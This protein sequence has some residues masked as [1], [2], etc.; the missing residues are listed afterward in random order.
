MQDSFH[1]AKVAE[2]YKSHRGQKTEEKKKIIGLRL[3]EN[4]ARRRM[5]EWRY[6]TLLLPQKDLNIELHN[7]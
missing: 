4:Q 7:N 1:D 5:G 6:I 2:I 3:T